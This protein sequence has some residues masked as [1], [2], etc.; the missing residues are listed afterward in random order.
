MR[1]VGL[2]DRYLR[3]FFVG[4]DGSSMRHELDSR[5][6]GQRKR[7]EAAEAELRR[8]RAQIRGLRGPD[9]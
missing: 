3:W 9:S 2:L 7:A 6:H 4:R 8:L 1:L 5:T